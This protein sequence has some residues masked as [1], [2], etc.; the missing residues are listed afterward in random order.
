MFTDHELLVLMGDV[1]FNV[2]LKTRKKNQHVSTWLTW[3][4]VWFYV[5]SSPCR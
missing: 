5:T 2:T 1:T 3:I 4:Q